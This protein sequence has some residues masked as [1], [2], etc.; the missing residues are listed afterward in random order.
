MTVTNSEIALLNFYRASELHGG[1]ILGQMV[2]RTRDPGLILS[3][4]RHSA[5]EVMHA[6]LWT[7]T[8]IAIGGKPAPVRDTYQTRYAEAVGT[9]LTLLEVLALTQVFERRVYR[10]FTLHLRVPGLHPVVAQTLQRMLEE[11]RGH[12]SWVKH[13]LDEQA[14][15]RGQEV[16]DVM[17][18]YA[19]VDRQIY[20]MLSSEYGLRWAA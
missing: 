6:Q 11:E 18:R 12:L 7:E 4:T 9:P 8:I 10:H 3:L 17:R 5:E 13:W 20:D 19:L 16:R 2:R 15:D 14:R 1:L